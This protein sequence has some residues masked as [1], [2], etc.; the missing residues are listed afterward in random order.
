[1]KE[2]EMKAAV[3]IV[4]FHIVLLS[5]SLGKERPLISVYFV[6]GDIARNYPPLKN[7]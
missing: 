5:G 7:H 4:F 6:V 2:G 1:M 3:K